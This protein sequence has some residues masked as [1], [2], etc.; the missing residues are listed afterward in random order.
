MSGLS[1]SEM[2]AFSGLALRRREASLL[3]DGR[4]TAKWFI[5]RVALRPRARGAVVRQ[6]SANE[7]TTVCDLTGVRNLFSAYFAAPTMTE[8]S[9]FVPKSSMS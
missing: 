4:L 1:T 8:R 3:R 7:V 2:S 6:Q 9:Y 5:H